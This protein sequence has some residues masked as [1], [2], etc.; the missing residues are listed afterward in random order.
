MH[1]CA[2]THMCAFSHNII[3]ELGY[4]HDVP[5]DF[6]FYVAMRQIATYVYMELLCMVA[7][8]VVTS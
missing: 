2:N 6:L 3:S 1:T 7:V 8:C 4:L 5:L